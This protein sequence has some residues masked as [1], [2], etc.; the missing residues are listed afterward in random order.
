MLT[1]NIIFLEI[2][3]GLKLKTGYPVSDLDTLN[4]SY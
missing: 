2:G 4:T 3:Y 1:E